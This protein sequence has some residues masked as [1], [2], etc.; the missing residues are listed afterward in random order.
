MSGQIF[1][2][3]NSRSGTTMV[4]RIL[5]RNSRV[6]DLR[7]LH[8]IEQMISGE[9]FSSGQ[10]LAR[11]RA[12]ELAAR[13]ISVIRDGYFY[14]TAGEAY[15]A[16]AEAAL[17][18]VEDWP[19]VTAAQLF[20]A[21]RFAEAKR[22]GKDIPIDQT[23]RNVFYI[24]DILAA[25]ADAKIVCM[26]RDPRD[27]CLS[28]KGKWRRRFLG[29]NI[30]IFEAIR[31]WANYHP[32]VTT[33]IWRQ[34]VRAGDAAASDPRVL[35]IRFEDITADPQGVVQRLC[36]HTGVAFEP[37]MLNV[38]RVGSSDRKDETGASGVD[39][40]RVGTWA[41]GGLSAAEIAICEKEA[42]ALLEAHGYEK[43][44]LKSNPFGILLWWGL[45]PLKMALALALNLRRVKNLLS[46]AR[47][48]IG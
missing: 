28:Q 44:G 30:P 12:L 31:S 15:R 2:V 7:E 13:L 4:A 1:V 45:L 33:R 16:D 25:Y 26:V 3:G 29:A 41:A 17:S 47:K 19:S 22:A 39:A 38:A 14:G 8:F 27:V 46:W 6:Q 42:G 24:T 23:P 36:T 21:V 35:V 37:E 34:A 9:E 20:E 10:A 5:G 40:S 48:R 11:E 18:S 43:S 32:V